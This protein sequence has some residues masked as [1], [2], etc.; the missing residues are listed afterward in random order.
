VFE[1]ELEKKGPEF[2]HIDEQRE[3]FIALNAGKFD[4]EVPVPRNI[5]G[6]E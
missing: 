3:E 4:F 5:V 1:I 6:I 2:S